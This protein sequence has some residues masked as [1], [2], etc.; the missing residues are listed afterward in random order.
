MLRVKMALI[1]A[2]ALMLSSGSNPTAQRTGDD[3]F[4]SERIIAVAEVTGGH[5][6]TV[7]PATSR[8]LKG[9]YTVRVEAIRP[10]VPPTTA[11]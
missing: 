1:G 9:T 2:L 4:R 5:T 3:E 8:A 10:R 11:G 7:R 6:V